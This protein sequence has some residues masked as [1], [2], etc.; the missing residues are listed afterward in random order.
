MAAL[1]SYYIHIT[2]RGSL[3]DPL[4]AAMGSSAQDVMK[5]LGPAVLMTVTEGCL[6]IQARPAL[7]TTAMGSASMAAVRL[8]DMAAAGAAAEFCINPLMGRL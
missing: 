8:A 2:L 4:T 7:V 3:S 6:L 5:V 1:Y